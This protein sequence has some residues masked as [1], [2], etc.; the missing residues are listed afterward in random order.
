MTP[1]TAIPRTMLLL[2]LLGAAAGCRRPE[3]CAVI[4]MTLGAGLPPRQMEEMGLDG[5]SLRHAALAALGESGGF[6]VPERQ[7]PD[8][9]PRCRASV[10]L[11]DARLATRRAP[12]GPPESAVTRLEVALEMQVEPVGGEGF[13]ESARWGEP[14][15]AGEPPAAALRRAVSGAAGKAAAALAMAMAETRKPDVEVIRDLDSGDPRQRDYAVRVLADRRNP[16]AVPRLVARLKDP[17]PAVVERAVGALG[18]IRDPRAVVPLIEL[19]YR[20]EPPFVAQ[21][22]R[23]IGDIGGAEAE[24]FLATLASGHA[25]A[26]VR[27]AAREALDDL[28]R[29]RA[30][31]E[32]PDAGI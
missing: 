20:R 21:V 19:T 3:R 8:A 31:P 24:A 1:G 29:G 4:G 28:R 5:E 15:R 6:L 32:R 25:D 13:A 10:A 9:G 30:A 27:R 12:D 22:A 11:L 2:A 26:G 17:D 16:A 7:P 14:I 23:I 18:Q